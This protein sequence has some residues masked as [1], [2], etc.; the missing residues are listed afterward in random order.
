M[1]VGLL[2]PPWAA[3]PP[4]GYGGTEAVIDQLARG[5]Q[6]AGHDVVLFTVAESTC[7]VPSRHLLA[8]AEG[9]RIGSCVPELRHTLAAYDAMSD[10]DIIHDHTMAG[11]IMAAVNGFT[12]IPVV[13][14][15]HG[16]F[17]DELN[18]LYRRI[19]SDV[20]VIAISADQASR[21][22]GVRIAKVIHHGVDP[23]AFPVGNGDGDYLLFLG[24]MAYEKG[25]HRAI[26]IARA[27]GKRLIIAAKMREESERRYFE[28]EIE[29]HLGGDVEFVGEAQGQQKL[30]LLG[31][32]EALLNP[33][34]WPEPF[35]MVMIEAL[36]CG[37]PI[38]SFPEGA[39]PEIITSGTNGF[40]GDTEDD[41]TS[42][43]RRL[44]HIDRDACRN[45]VLERFS[46]THMTRN[47][48]DLY[49][50]VLNQ[51]H[52]RSTPPLMSIGA[53]ALSTAD[54]TTSSHS[55]ADGEIARGPMLKLV[56]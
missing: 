6:T 53:L 21:A 43:I 16:P 36:A 27:A 45:S 15:N 44:E 54:L 35:G 34:R 18:D 46:T 10:V 31:G 48:L 39:A 38:I 9:M 17:N 2:A 7:P 32:A 52:V 19:S 5:I 29:P 4:V 37:T 41:L 26:R 40:L 30:E 49:Q 28:A 20:G 1:K 3:I 25:A 14:T 23:D 50:A 11:P 8:A 12:D 47:H 33:I 42:A 56:P 13:T 24:R 51:S 55:A 22:T